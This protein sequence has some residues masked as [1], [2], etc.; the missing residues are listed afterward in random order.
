MDV[1]TTNADD[2][3]LF[4]EPSSRSLQLRGEGIEDLTVYSVSGSLFV[5]STVKGVSSVL[6]PNLKPGIYL[7]TLKGMLGKKVIKF[8]LN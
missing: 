3:S 1:K 8:I 7:A 4:V 6:L 2:W 5:K